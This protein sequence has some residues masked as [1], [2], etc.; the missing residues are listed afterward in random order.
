[1]VTEREVY[2]GLRGGEVVERGGGG[3]RV[4]AGDPNPLGLVVMTGSTPTHT[5]VPVD[6]KEAQY[7][8]A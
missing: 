3:G 1:M 4:G 7:A 6:E 8:P 2:C 5:V